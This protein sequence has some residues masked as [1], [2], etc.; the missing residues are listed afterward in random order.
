MQLAKLLHAEGL[1]TKLTLRRGL[2]HGAFIPLSVLFPTARIPV[3][4]ISLRANM[5]MSEHVLLGRTLAQFRCKGTMI[6]CECCGRVMTTC[7]R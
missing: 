5:N 3:V 4:Q 2:D 7:M 6:I 1:P